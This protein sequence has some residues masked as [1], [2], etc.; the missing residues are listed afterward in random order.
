M[1]GAGF[2]EV[3]ENAD[4]IIQD[5]PMTAIDAKKDLNNAFIADDSLTEY[6]TNWGNIYDENSI[7][8][9]NDVY[10][11][12][13]DLAPAQPNDLSH[14]SHNLSPGMTLEEAYM[15][16]DIRESFLQRH[17]NPMISD[18]EVTELET[19]DFKTKI[20]KTWKT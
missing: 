17:V 2:D 13:E 6:Q 8:A 11:K 16:H 4:Y 20:N 7:V 18:C 14:T 19:S 12:I 10:G 15:A 9:N 5:T 1:P 3:A